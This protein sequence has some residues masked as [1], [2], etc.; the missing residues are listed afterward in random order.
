MSKWFGITVVVLLAFWLTLVS[1]AQ[2]TLSAASHAY[3]RLLVQHETDLA[4]IRSRLAR[5]M[6]S[7]KP[8]PPVALPAPPLRQQE[9]PTVVGSKPTSHGI[10]LLP[11]HACW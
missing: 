1:I 4:G 2:R 5:Q 7:A 8:G 10:E 3:G 9:G 11:E 6:V